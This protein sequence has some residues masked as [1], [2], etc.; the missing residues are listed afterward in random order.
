MP[1]KVHEFTALLQN[2]IASHWHHK[3]PRWGELAVHPGQVLGIVLPRRAIRVNIGW[4]LG[5]L[6]VRLQTRRLTEIAVVGTLT[7][8]TVRPKSI[9]SNDVCQCIM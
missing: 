3:Q 5:D 7:L 4:K 2:L 6:S 8:E 9:L 1:G